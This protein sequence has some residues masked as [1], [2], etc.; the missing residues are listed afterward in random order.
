M[1]S[2]FVGVVAMG[3]IHCVTGLAD[4]KNEGEIWVGI[5]VN[6]CIMVRDNYDYSTDTHCQCVDKSVALTV[7]LPV[8]SVDKT[9]L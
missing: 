4:V 3:D 5:P 7:D 8:E 9:E 2:S 6:N 1:M